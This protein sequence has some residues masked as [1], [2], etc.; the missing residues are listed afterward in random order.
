MTRRRTAPRRRSSAGS[1]STRPPGSARAA[2]RCRCRWSELEAVTVRHYTSRAGDPHR[3]LHL[4]INARVFAAGTVAR[5]AHR[6]G[7]GLARRDQRHRARRGDDRSGVPGRARR[8]RLHPRRRTGEIVQLADFVG[9]FSA[10]AAQIAPQLD[11]YEARVARGAPRR[12][13]PGP[14]LRRAWDARAWAEGRPDKVVPQRGADLDATLASRELHGLGYRDPD[15]PRRL[16]ADRRSARWTATQAV[17]QVLARLAARPVGVERRRHP[18][19][20]RAADRRRTA[21]SPT[22]RCGSSWPRTSPPARWRR[23]V[24]LL[25]RRGGAG[26]RPGPDLAAGA[27]RRGR[28][29]RPARRPRRARRPGRPRADRAADG[30]DR[31]GCRPACGGRRAGRRP[32]AGRGGGRGRRRQDHHPGRRPRPLDRAGAA[33]CVV[34]TPT[35]KAAKVAARRG[36]RR[37]RVGGVAGLPARLALERARHVD[38]TRRRRRRPG[39]RPRPHRPAT[40]PRLRPRDLLL[41]DEA[42]MLDQDTARALLTIADEHRRPGRAG[43]GP[44]PAAR[45]RPRRRARPRRPL[46]RTRTR[47]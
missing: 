23:C 2:G 34:V 47:A 44:A 40:R 4:Q 7:P 16:D 9:P 11:R 19:R 22:P 42:G 1:R 26:A 17:E 8:A 21:S 37:R 10:R 13:E 35:L 38:P 31:T 45:G 18:R 32:A 41:V 43:R 46:G 33:G 36:R 25:D 5:A 15:R 29:D 27:R 20:G 24:P 28:P 6:R 3:H 14:A 30:V 12:H 39:H